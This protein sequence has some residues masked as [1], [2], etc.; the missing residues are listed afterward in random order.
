MT[1][2]R[3][4][5][6]P[7]RILVPSTD[8]WKRM[9]L[10]DK[11]ML[12]LR[13]TGTLL[14]PICFYGHYLIISFPNGNG[15]SFVGLVRYLFS[16]PDVKDNRLAFLSQNICQDPLEKFCGCQ[17]RGGTSDNPNAQEFYNNTGALR[18]I[19]SFCRGPAKGNGRGAGDVH[20]HILT[21]KENE[22]LQRHRKKKRVIMVLHVRIIIILCITLS[23]IWNNITKWL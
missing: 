23:V 4:S 5:L 19:N 1:G 20:M 6:V 18:V 9:L 13:M 11:T 12:G 2:S 3:V 15:Q 10:S 21:E 7:S 16:L 22:P 14:A 17:R 8:R